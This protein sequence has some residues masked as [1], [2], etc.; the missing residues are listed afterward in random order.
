MGIVTSYKPNTIEGVPTQEF[1]RRSLHAFAPAPHGHQDLTNA[2]RRLNQN[3][4]CFQAFLQGI[5]QQTWPERTKDYFNVIKVI[6]KY[7]TFK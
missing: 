5:K 3:K 7:I 6:K 1:W 2:N 4:P